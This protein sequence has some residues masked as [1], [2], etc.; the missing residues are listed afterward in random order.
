MGEAEGSYSPFTGPSQQ[1][2][3]WGQSAN[4]GCI[5]LL[6]PE[7]SGETVGWTSGAWL[8]FIKSIND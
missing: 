8:L 3:L 2:S 5:L 7:Y 4:R 6:D 1:V